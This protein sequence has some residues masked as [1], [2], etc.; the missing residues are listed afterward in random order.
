MQENKFIIVSVGYNCINYIDD[1]FNSINNQTFLQDMNNI[2]RLKLLII[3]DASTDGTYEYLQTKL[4]DF[5]YVT[6]IKNKYNMN[7]LYNKTIAIKEHL[8]LDDEDIII[9]IDL[10]DT[11]ELN[12]LEKINNIYQNENIWLTYGSFNPYPNLCKELNWDVSLRNQEWVTSHLHTYK[13]FLFKN[14]L[15]KDLIDNN[16]EYY[17]FPEDRIRMY[18]LL[19][20]AGKE[21]IYFCKDILYNYRIH[22]NNDMIINND[23]CQN[24]LK[25]ILDKKPYNKKTKEE[26]LNHECDW[27]LIPKQIYFYWG[28]EKMSFMRYMTLKSCRYYHPDWDII[29]ITRNNKSSLQTKVY[30]EEQDNNY[31]DGEDYTNKLDDLNLIYENIEEDYPEIGNLNLSDNYNDDI[32]GWYIL[33]YKGGF[34]CDMDVLFTNTIYYKKLSETI[35]SDKGIGVFSYY[36]NFACGMLFSTTSYHYKNIYNLSLNVLKDNYQSAGPNLLTTYIKMNNIKFFE[37][38]N[39]MIYPYVDKDITPVWKDQL[40]KPYELNVFHNPGP[41]NFCIHWYGGWPTSK[42]YNQLLTEKNYKEYNNTLTY[43]IKKVLE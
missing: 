18:N 13:W 36:N 1:W 16:R 30:I 40:E 28:N 7:A 32:V 4:K 15:R 33:G 12:A 9:N 43:F 20:M 19:E 41:D 3:D 17:K 11:L 8:N 34:K 35:N 42:H 37:F 38:N 26:L 24:I 22:N 10:D 5:E 25:K 14:I 21:H 2:K 27:L 23:E 39:K 29:L 6:L 31:F